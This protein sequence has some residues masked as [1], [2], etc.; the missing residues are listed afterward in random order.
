MLSTL[1]P[2]DSPWTGPILVGTLGTLVV[3][4]SLTAYISSRTPDARAR[5]IGAK[6]PPGPE[7]SFLVGNLFNF[8]RKRW[9]E[10]FTKWSEDFG[11]II[12]VNVAGVTMVVLNSLEITQQL[13][14][15]PIYN[16]RPYKTMTNELMYTNHVMIVAQP[17]PTFNEQRKVFRKV[18]G[19]QV[20][21][22]YD[23]LIEQN[24]EP[25]LTA[26]SG[27][28]GDPYPIL[29]DA[30]GAV[31]IKLGYGD[32][33]YQEHGKELIDLNVRRMKLINTTFAKFWMVDIFPSL[34]HIPAWFPG[35]GFRRLGQEATLLG[36][37]ARYWAFGMAEQAMKEGTADDSVVRRYLDEDV[38]A[39]DQL[40][41]AIALMYST[42]VDTTSTA[43]DNLIYSMLLH[44]NVQRRVHAELDGAGAGPDR[45]LSPSE[46]ERLPLF[47]AVF[48]E[49]L[50]WNPPA[51]NGV[52]HVNTQEDVWNGY[53]IPKGSL[54]NCNIGFFMRD[55]RIWGEDS[56]EFKPERFL[57]VDSDKLPD[58][59]SVPFGFGRRRVSSAYKHF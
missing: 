41:D 35:A 43:I 12:Y 2:R 27:Y 25:L 14:S 50:R 9:F 52:P 28:S 24:I 23:G 17:G 19:A 29:Q 30:V 46:I 1:H 10:T 48:K 51:I 58:M 26:L 54:I 11:D 7:R 6:L 5:R 21:S 44:P 55:P 57:D 36:K 45:I 49:S 31:I 22:S 18:L 15:K 56:Q 37:K 59:G 40:R 42:G 53:Y 34:R 13:T 33:I 20:V 4:G 3:F 32:K 16:G 47:Q 38:F 8:P 39:N